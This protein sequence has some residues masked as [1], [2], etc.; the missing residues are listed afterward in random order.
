MRRAERMI[1]DDTKMLA[2]VM[3][4]FD[5]VNI[6]MTDGEYPYVVPM[7]F[8]YSVNDEKLTIYVHSAPEG[9]KVDIFRR[10]PKVCC[11]LSAFRNFYH[12]P[13]NGFRHDYRSVIAFGKIHKV[14]KGTE[15]FK[16]GLNRLL[17]QYGRKPG[18]FQAESIK[19]MELYAIECDRSNV[20]GKAEFPI[21]N[22]AD[23][24]FLNFEA[25]YEAE[26]KKRP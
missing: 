15:E 2:D 18:E 14:E 23:V 10:S 4:M 21:K 17:A 3:D 13:V 16:N 6:A 25:I 5:T 24:P 7:S 26:T 11:A 1:P 9:H 8:G 20:T 22:E 19:N 12:K